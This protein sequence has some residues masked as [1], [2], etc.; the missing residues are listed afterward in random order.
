MRELVTARICFALG[1][2]VLFYMAGTHMLPAG[3]IG[4]GI[5]LGFVLVCELV[6]ARNLKARANPPLS[7]R[8]KRLAL[9]PWVPIWL[10]IV[11]A[12]VA[13]FFFM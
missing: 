13:P 2:L 7:V 4:G 11:A 3:P 9:I 1:V 12:L 5:I 8:Q 10:M 6:V